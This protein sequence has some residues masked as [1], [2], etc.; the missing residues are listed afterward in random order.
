MESDGHSARTGIAG[1]AG[2]YHDLPIILR[3]R[4]PYNCYKSA[5]CNN[6]VATCDKCPYGCV[7]IVIRRLVFTIKVEL[8]LAG[9]RILLISAGYNDGDDDLN[10]YIETSAILL[11]P[12]IPGLLC[13]IN[14]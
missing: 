6:S 11:V 9:R 4:R 13:Q 5:A 3:S 2:C 12:A 14:G 8:T 7:M 1:R 10:A